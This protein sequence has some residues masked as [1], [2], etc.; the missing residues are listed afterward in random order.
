MARQSYSIV[1]YYGEQD[2]YKCGYCK[3]PN[4]NFSHGMGTH[5]LTVQDYQAL[6]DRGWRRC[7]SYCYKSTMDQTCCPMYTIKCEALQ[8]KIS[9]SQKK[10]LKRMAK[11]LRNELHKDDTMDTYDGDFHNN[12]DIEEIPNHNKHFLKVD[13]DISDMN[14]KFISDEVNARLHP[15][16]SDRGQKKHGLENKKHNS[17]SVPAASSYNNDSHS[18]P[19]S[20]QSVEM[21]PT[22]IPCMKAKL[23]RKQRKQNKLMTQGKTQEEIEAIFKENKQEN[24]AKSLEQIFDEVYNGT[25]RLELKLV[26][27]SPMSSGYLNT[28]KQSYEVYKKYQTTIHGVLA[29]K[30]TEMQYMGFLVNSPLQMKLVRTMSDEFIKTLKISANLFKKYQMT[31]HGETEKESDDKS[32]FNFLVKSSLQPWTP[33]DGPPSGYGSFHEQYWLDNELIAVGVIDILPS[34]VSSVYFFYDPAYSHLSLGTFSS[35]REVYLTRQLNKI[36]KD[37]KYYYMGFYIHSCP[38][39]RYKA[40]M[41]PS[42]LLCPET[43]AWFDIEPCLLKLDK[44]KYSRLNDDIDAINED[45]IVDIRKVLILYRQIAMPYEIYKKQAQTITQDEEDEIKEY[46]SLVGMKCA[47]RLLLYRC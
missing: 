42:K 17:E 36:A 40:R 5:R 32:F 15:S 37:L 20:L 41:R 27:T 35:L 3:S 25:N 6:V 39:M 23:L 2:G 19:Q 33:D 7:G 26:R 18:T 31:I 14:V 1:E 44:Q 9:K 46:T 34:C 22:R 11:F 38:K 13:K 21:N 4:T 12:I 30:V 43:Y 24:Q 47:Q 10:V 28:S 29:E 16:T 45:N 8:F